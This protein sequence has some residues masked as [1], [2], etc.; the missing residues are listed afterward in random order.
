MLKEKRKGH[1]MNYVISDIHG[2]RE[3]LLELLAKIQFSETDTLYVL[4]DVL[5]R[6][7]DPM[8]TLRDLMERK[9]IIFIIGNHDYLFHYFVKRL[10]FD[11][12]DFQ[13]EDD[14]WDLRSWLKDGGL[15]TMDSFLELSDEKKQQ[16][17]VYLENAS[18]YEEFECNEK[19]YVLTHA[20]IRDFEE[21]KALEEYDFADFIS[22]RADYSCRYFKDENTIL[23]T[24]HTPTPCIREDG[25]P[26]V[27]IG[28]GHI[29]MDCGCVFGGRLAAYCFE[30]EKVT[31][32]EGVKRC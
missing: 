8:G 21:G 32:V 20:G 28:N 10:G 19:K 24:G 25:K 26:E 15:P 7:F 18:L 14:K 16:I 6:G 31:Y 12:M 22:G 5:D 17:V 23:V 9:N 11:L 27:Y 3:Q 1:G 13:H 30:T 4:G 2:C 29:A